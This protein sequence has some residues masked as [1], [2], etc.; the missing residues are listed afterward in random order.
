MGEG[1]SSGGRRGGGIGLGLS[2]NEYVNG[3]GRGNGPGFGG[4][5]SGS[6]GGAGSGSGGG[7]GFARRNSWRHKKLDMPL[8]DGTNLD[9]WI[10]RA[11]RFF[12]FYG[13]TEE[14]KV[15]ATL[16]ALEGQALLWFQ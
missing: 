12:S 11:E 8:F 10:L 1:S 13:L 5:R 3:S 6:G 16:V 7:S 15:E 14:E 2:G 9:G 4:V